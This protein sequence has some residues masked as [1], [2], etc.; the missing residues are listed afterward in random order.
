MKGEKGKQGMFTPIGS[1]Q[2]M[3]IVCKMKFSIDYKKLWYVYG[4][5]YLTRGDKDIKD[6]NNNDYD[7]ILGVWIVYP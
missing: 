5:K 6:I 4:S 1:T 7:E 3:S 2:S